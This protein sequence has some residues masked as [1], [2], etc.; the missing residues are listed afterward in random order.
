MPVP[1]ESEAR[2]LGEILI[3]TLKISSRSELNF[4]AIAK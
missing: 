4:V 3:S 2:P 1:E